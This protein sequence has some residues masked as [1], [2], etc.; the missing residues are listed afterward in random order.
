MSCE[1]KQTPSDFLNYASPF[2]FGSFAQAGSEVYRIDQQAFADTYH[3]TV[4]VTDV[5]TV[6]GTAAVRAGGAEN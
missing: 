5:E 3:R 6:A 1:G 2:L 4:A